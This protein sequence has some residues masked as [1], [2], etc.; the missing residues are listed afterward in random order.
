[1][2]EFSQISSLRLLAQAYLES[3]TPLLAEGTAALETL[4]EAEP[5]SPSLFRR[6]IK[7]IVS[8]KHG[9]NKIVESKS[10]PPIATPLTIV[11]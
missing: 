5:S 10:S 11:R 3:E 1:M 2:F 9:Q 4:L 6:Y 8:Q 7:L